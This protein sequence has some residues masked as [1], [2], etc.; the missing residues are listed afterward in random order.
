MPDNRKALLRYKIL[1]KCPLKLAWAITIHKSQGMTFD[2]M[3]FDLTRGIFAPGQTYVAISRMRSL[4][5]LTLSNSIMP[6]HVIQNSEILAFANSFNDIEMIDDELEIGKQVYRYYSKKDYTM[7][8]QVCLEL[9]MTKIRKHDFR[10]AALLTKRMFDV[11]L[12]D[13]HL[14]G[15]TCD[16]P[17]LKTCSMTCHFLNAVICLYGNRYEEAVGYADMVLGRKAC[18]EAMFMK[19]RA[20]YELK[21][22]DEAFDVCYQILSE[23]KKAEDKKAIDMKQLLLEA[24]VNEQIG[25]PNRDICKQLIKLCPEY[26][27][28][29]MMLRRDVL[30]NDSSNDFELDDDSSSTR[31]IQS[32]YDVTMLEN[33]FEKILK[34][35]NKN[36]GEFSAF[37]KHIYKIAV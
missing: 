17:L 34:D 30:K 16:V 11:M 6:H 23:S 37:K 12:D 7:A 13:A 22:Y 32:F 15:R 2:R 10:N 27:P 8:S 19:G 36:S 28:A 31:L 25:N 33:G 14:L 24:K 4:E 5:G 29:Y 21:R 18:L 1:D 9:A 3:H 26:I 20:L 35:T